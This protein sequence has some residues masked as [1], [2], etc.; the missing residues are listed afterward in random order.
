MFVDV[1]FI[2]NITKDRF[3][4]NMFVQQSSIHDNI[5]PR[6]F[7]EFIGISSSLI[8]LLMCSPP[9][10]LLSYHQVTSLNIIAYSY[11][12]V[13]E[14]WLCKEYHQPE[15]IDCRHRGCWGCR[16]LSHDCPDIRGSGHW[17]LSR[18]GRS[19]CRCYCYVRSLHTLRPVHTSD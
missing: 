12:D 16:R 2:T 9:L 14:S 11:T 1:H 6:I 19:R 4:D 18:N 3:A 13:T 8:M 17:D 10:T 7:N 15:E 5:R